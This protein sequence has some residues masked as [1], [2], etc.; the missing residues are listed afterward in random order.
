M[1][2]R[3]KEMRKLLNAQDLDTVSCLFQEEQAFLSALP[4]LKLDKS[5]Y[6]RSKRNVLTS[7]AASCYPLHFV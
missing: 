5:I 6:E 1:E 7:G 4:L 2:W 3:A